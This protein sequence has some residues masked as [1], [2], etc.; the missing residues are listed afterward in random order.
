VVSVQGV[1]AVTGLPTKELNLEQYLEKCPKHDVPFQQDRYC[2]ECKFKWPKQN[3]LCTTGTHQGLLW[4][5]GFRTPDG[6][7]RQYV[8]TEQ[9]ARGVA[10]AVIG[11]DRV[12]AVGIGFY[13][14]KEPKPEPTVRAFRGMVTKCAT[15]SLDMHCDESESL[16]MMDAPG[17]ETLGAPAAAPE[18]E[19]TGHKLKRRSRRSGSRK[20]QSK[21]YEVAAGASINQDVFPDPKDIDFWEETPA[22]MIYVNYCDENTAFQIIESGK[23]DESTD[24]FLQNIP[25]GN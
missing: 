9:E 19:L 4:L 6:K 7:V 22:G 13:L 12:F 3:Y 8:F 1:N 5:D 23:R 11:E 2:P 16:N 24:G 15:A 21:S 17:L 25:V 18:K 20:I 10:K 14:S